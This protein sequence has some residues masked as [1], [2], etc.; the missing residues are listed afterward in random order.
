MAK[1]FE[2][3]HLNL[4]QKGATTAAPCKWRNSLLQRSYSI[5]IQLI[6]PK[7]VS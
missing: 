4:I 2:I 3:H 1:K 5:L 7:A 6:L